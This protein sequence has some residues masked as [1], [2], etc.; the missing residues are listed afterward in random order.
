MELVWVPVPRHQQPG[1]QR[2]QP[3]D[4]RGCALPDTLSHSCSHRP[5][6]V[7]GWGPQPEQGCLH[8]HTLKG[9]EGCRKGGEENKRS[10]KLHRKH[11]GEREGREERGESSPLWSSYPR[12]SSQSRQIY[13]RELQPVEM[14]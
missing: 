3:G 7:H 14:T 9:R 8:E 1:L 5:T 2:P 4:T 13:L 11:Q 6:T 12:F 10:G